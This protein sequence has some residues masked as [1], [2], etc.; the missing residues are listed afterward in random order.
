MLWGGLWCGG[1]VSRKVTLR[2]W[3]ACTA[4]TGIT[5]DPLIDAKYFLT[6]P[7]LSH[8]PS[9]EWAVGLLFTSVKV[10]R[11]D[12]DLDTSPAGGP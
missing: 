1:S 6:G 5:D 4:A 11:R 8:L 7:D 12:S 10:F 3:R 2:P 9:P